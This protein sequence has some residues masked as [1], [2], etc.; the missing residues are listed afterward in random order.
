MAIKIKK[1]YNTAKVHNNLTNAVH[2]YKT[3]IVAGILEQCDHQIGTHIYSC[4]LSTATIEYSCLS[5]CLSVFGC[6]SVRVHDN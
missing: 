5:V 6:I 1:H 3:H 2:C 4:G